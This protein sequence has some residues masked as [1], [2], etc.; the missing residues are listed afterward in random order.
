MTL[1]RRTLVASLLAPTALAL[2][3]FAGPAAAQPDAANYPT[4]AIRMIVGFPGGGI[5]DV[6]ARAPDGTETRKLRTEKTI[7]A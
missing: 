2:A 1:H 7:P 5:T 4:R 6:I 3:G